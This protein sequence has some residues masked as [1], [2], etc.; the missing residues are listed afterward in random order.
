MELII[1]NC[2]CVESFYCQHK[3]ALRKRAS[4]IIDFVL[5][6]KS[7]SLYS[8]ASPNSFSFCQLVLAKSKKQHFTDAVANC[9]LKAEIAASS[10][11]ISF[12]VGS[13]KGLSSRKTRNAC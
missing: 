7:L 8:T 12:C 1:L 13:N 6:L 3:V 5:F 4:A 9:D 2:C 10:K 11:G